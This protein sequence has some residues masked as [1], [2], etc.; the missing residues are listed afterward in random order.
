M[1]TTSTFNGDRRPVVAELLGLA[2]SGKT[3]LSRALAQRDAGIGEGVR[4]GRFLHARCWTSCLARF[5]PAVVGNGDRGFGFVDRGRLRS[6]VYLDGWHRV[7]T[8]A[9]AD[10]AWAVLLDHGPLYRL[11]H[12]AGFGAPVRKTVGLDRWCDAML[13]RWREVLDLVVWLDAP[14]DTLV[15]RIQSRGRWHVVKEM[16]EATAPAFLTQHR[17]ALDRL[18]ADVSHSGGPEILRFDTGRCATE[19]IAEDVLAALRSRRRAPR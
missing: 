7:L 8:R 10:A 16:P 15:E 17:D 14:T 18:L 13:R 6:M 1:R 12:L 5:A 3:T 4:L 11:A 9:P 19:T 2:G